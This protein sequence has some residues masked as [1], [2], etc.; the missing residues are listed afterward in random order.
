[1]TQ[2]VEYLF[3]KCEALSSNHSTTKGEKNKKHIYS[4]L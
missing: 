3:S 4:I 2:V 1:M